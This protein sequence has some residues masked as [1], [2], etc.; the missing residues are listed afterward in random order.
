MTQMGADE[1]NYPGP[2]KVVGQWLPSRPYANEL[3]GFLHAEGKRSALI[4][5]L[6]R[7]CSILGLMVVAGT[8]MAQS[9]DSAEVKFW[10]QPY[11]LVEY[12]LDGVERL[13]Q[14][15]Y[16]AARFT[17]GDHRL[18]FWAP[19]CSILDTTIHVVGGTD[20]ALRKVLKQTPE[21]LANKREHFK[22]WGQKALWK[23]L[24][25]LLTVGFGMKAFSDKQAHDQA[26]DDLHALQDSYAT[27]LSPSSIEQTKANTIPVAQGELDATRRRMTLSL[28]LCGVGAV[29]TVYGFI[30]AK[31]LSYPEYQDK[32]KIRFDGLAWLPTGQGGMYLA[33]LSIP[34]R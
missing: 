21:Y 11:N 3:K 5:M 6:G 17:E 34:L 16:P 25:L 4:G 22:V 19:N 33:Q 12:I 27:M 31:K 32:E 8:S 2:V 1:C 13:K 18:L 24:P 9:R 10:V 26:Y 7:V 23:G 15:E 20:M 14:V 30:R 28:A 29:A